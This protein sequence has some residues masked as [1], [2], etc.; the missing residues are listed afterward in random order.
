MTMTDETEV[1]WSP[2]DVA[3]RLGVS[4]SGL[5]RLAGVYAQL[6]GELPKDSGGTSRQWPGEAV[7]RLEQARALMAAG[8]ARSIRDA[9][10]AVESGVTPSA[11]AALALGQEGRVVEALGVVAARLEALQ[12][13]NARLE[14]EVAALRSE[15]AE[16]RALPAS[17]RS[18]AVEGD[19][20]SAP[21]NG[22]QTGA[23]A[24]SE[25]AQDSI[26]GRP[27]L[28]VKAAQRLERWLWHRR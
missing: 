17:E 23:E 8:Q 20:D 24:A 14:A 25:P 7:Y 19:Q 2:G 28:L 27:G 13:S 6:Y 9:L 10:L 26:E 3:K 18:P 16:V 12:E 15:L 21:P 22:A 11:D 5:R 4:P 1:F